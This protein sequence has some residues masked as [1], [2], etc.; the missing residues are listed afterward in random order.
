MTF[1]GGTIQLPNPLLVLDE[2]WDA[3]CHVPTLSAHCRVTGI[4]VGSP[5]AGVGAAGRAARGSTWM[6]M[7]PRAL[8]QSASHL[9]LSPFILSPYCFSEGKEIRFPSHVTGAGRAIT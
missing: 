2:E 4:Q 3:H 6:W 8:A 9:L 1:G 7:D 5:E